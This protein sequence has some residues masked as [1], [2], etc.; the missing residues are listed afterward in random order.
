MCKKV[1]KIMRLLTILYAFFS[2]VRG[3]RSR[4]SGISIYDRPRLSG[5]FLLACFPTHICCAA[6]EFKAGDNIEFIFLWRGSLD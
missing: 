3:S 4:S 1:K 5:Y 2:Y 6:G